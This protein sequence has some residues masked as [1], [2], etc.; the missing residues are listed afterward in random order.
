MVHALKLIPLASFIWPQHTT[1]TP[2]YYTPDVTPC[3]VHLPQASTMEWKKRRYWIQTN[4]Q[5]LFIKL[6]YWQ[7]IYFHTIK[8]H[9]FWNTNHLGMLLLLHDNAAHFPAH[10]PSM[11]P[12][13]PPKWAYR[14]LLATWCIHFGLRNSICLGKVMEP[15]HLQNYSRGWTSTLLHQTQ[16]ICTGKNYYYY[17]FS[18]PT[19]DFPLKLDSTFILLVIQLL[20]CQK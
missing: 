16:R 3:F 20:T 6:E 11:L 8:N 9:S 18:Q 12:L 10:G 5:S 2:A 7:K 15:Q 17:K 1:F 13:Q 14:T 19:S 4:H